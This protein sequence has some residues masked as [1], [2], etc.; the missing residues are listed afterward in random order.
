MHN[1]NQTAQ[2]SQYAIAVRLRFR[3]FRARH[4]IPGNFHSYAFN[5]SAKSEIP[6]IKDATATYNSATYTSGAGAGP[7]AFLELRGDIVAF[8]DHAVTSAFNHLAHRLVGIGFDDADHTQ[9]FRS[10]PRFEP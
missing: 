2:V 10:L 3:D 9:E 4:Y 8:L 6:T 5:S 7:L 1:C